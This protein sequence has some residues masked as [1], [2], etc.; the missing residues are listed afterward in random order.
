MRGPRAQDDELEA[1]RRHPFFAALAPDA[2]RQLRLA[3][4]VVVLGRRERLWRQGAP[5]TSIG[6]LLAGRCKISREDSGKEVILGVAN[7]G[8]LI[9]VVGFALG[10]GYSAGVVCLRR[11]RVLV[12]PAAQVRRAVQSNA[13]ALAALSVNLANEVSRLME[14]AQCLSAGNVER[15]LAS[16]LLALAE[17]AGEPFPGG[18]LIPM[19]LRRADLAAL[20]A[21]TLESASRTIS[22]FRRR[23]LI[24]LQPAGYLLR[25]LD[26]LRAL[27]AGRF[28]KLGRPR[29]PGGHP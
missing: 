20:S 5:A 2:L 29:G 26:S 21:T 15:R 4:R 9:G 28:D 25:D 18:L 3:S 22:G 16:V 7:P 17:R 12:L 14:M 8:E 23:G 27:A 24:V 1:L 19:R 10:A 6:L 13:L 11:A